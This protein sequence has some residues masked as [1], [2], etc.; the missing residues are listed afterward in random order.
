MQ[1][2]YN[3]DQSKKRKALLSL[4][5]NLGDRSL[6]LLRAR[7]AI[8]QRCRIL[9][10]S[11]EL[12]NSA[13]I[14]TDQPD[15]LNQIIEIETEDS[16]EDLL[17]FLKGIE[18]DLGRL[19]RRRYGPREIDLDILIFE[20]V[21][22]QTEELRLPHPGLLD[23]QYLHDLLDEPPFATEEKERHIRSARKGALLLGLLLLLPFL[24]APL[25]A[26]PAEKPALTSPP[27]PA[28]L[29]LE[30]DGSFYYRLS[31]ATGPREQK[32]AAEALRLHYRDFKSP[33]HEFKTDS[34]SPSL[35]NDLAILA[36]ED[37]DLEGAE[38]LF[39]L[40][41]VKLDALPTRLNLI[42]LYLLQD[43]AEGQAMLEDVLRKLGEERR[44]SALRALRNRRFDSA[45]DHFLRLWLQN[46]PLQ[47]LSASLLTGAKE[48]AALYMLTDRLH[49]AF[50]LYQE[51]DRRTATTDPQV[52]YGLAFLTEELTNDEKQAM[53]LYRQLVALADPEDEALRRYARLL[54]RHGDY[55]SVEST[56]A[57]LK[58]PTLDDLRM[59]I[60][61]RLRQNADADVEPLI[62]S[63]SLLPATETRTLFKAGQ[64]GHAPTLLDGLF[65]PPLQAVLQNDAPAYL[66]LEIFGS[67]D[68]N[69]IE[70]D[71]RTQRSIY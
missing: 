43:I 57:R 38:A 6:Y 2:D 51:I 18:K 5:S 58:E 56:L 45:A 42:F 63:A 22:M 17:A 69:T 41:L 12:N 60:R 23:R 1:Q 53:A 48:T 39:R 61:A 46:D 4:G 3:L 52:L 27:A 54:A 62:Q 28:A 14:V 64:S 8:A 55:A 66:R 65:L 30:E 37:R 59:R 34:L 29:P 26:A 25:L 70:A 44:L 24:W 49:E 35:L 67:S 16:P 68:R 7:E 20:G 32:A 15:F 31:T 33:F 9:R 11:R 21:E 47:P 10:A 36:A 71:R 40:S 19:H 13:L 50:S